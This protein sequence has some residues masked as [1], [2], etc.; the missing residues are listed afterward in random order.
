MTR[1]VR[2]VRK[3]VSFPDA[4]LRVMK[5]VR[6]CMGITQKR[7]D[8]GVR[9]YVVQQRVDLIHK[10]TEVAEMRKRKLSNDLVLQ[11]LKIEDMKMK[12][13]YPNASR[14]RYDPEDLTDP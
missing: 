8:E 14:R 11:D 6:V 3:R 7:I 2:I 9:D 10:Q 4:F 5:L 12:L 13:G 1:R